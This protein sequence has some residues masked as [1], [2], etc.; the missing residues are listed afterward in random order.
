MEDRFTND[1]DRNRWVI[2]FTYLWDVSNLLGGGFKYF[3]FTP[4]PWGDDPNL[5]S[6]FFRWFETTNY[7]L[8][9]LRG[10]FNPLILSIMDILVDDNYQDVSVDLKVLVLSMRWPARYAKTTCGEC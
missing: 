5:T 6:I 2:N 9:L 4:D 7:S 10:F 3:F 1:R 8:P